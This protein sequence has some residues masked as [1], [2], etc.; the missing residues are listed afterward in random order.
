MSKKIS[1]VERNEA[2]EAVRAICQPGTTLYTVIR[3][4]A[5]S[6][7]SRTLDVYAIQDGAPRYLSGYVA[8]ILGLTRTDN[9][10]RIG[11]C[12]F[13]AGFHVVQ[14]LSYAIHGMESTGDDAMAAQKRGTPFSP[15]PDAYRAGYS[16][17]HEWL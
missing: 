12:G 16:L 8:T 10:L 7:M 11:G 17:R 3:S 4:V 14:N 2:I 1:K 9:G 15:R 13:D 6:G 5:K